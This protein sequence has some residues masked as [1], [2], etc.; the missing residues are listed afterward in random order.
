[1]AGRRHSAPPGTLFWRFASNGF[2]GLFTL[3]LRA[4]DALPAAMHS[5]ASFQ[6]STGEAAMKNLDTALLSAR[7]H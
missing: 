4:L 2:R 1:M 6:P 7:A 5:A 3:A